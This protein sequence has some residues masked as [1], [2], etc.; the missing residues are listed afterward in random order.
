M[1]TQLHRNNYTK[2]ILLHNKLFKGIGIMKHVM[3]VLIYLF[4]YVS[5][6]WKTPFVQIFPENTQI[7]VLLVVPHP[8]GLL[9]MHMCYTAN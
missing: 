2:I 7:Q 4:I 5:N 3:L 1:F 6:L 8:H 9:T